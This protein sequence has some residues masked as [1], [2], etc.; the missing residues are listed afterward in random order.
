MTA[1]NRKARGASV[2]RPQDGRRSGTAIETALIEPNSL[3][4]EGVEHILARTRFQVVIRADA[5]SALDGIAAVH[6]APELAILWTEGGVHASIADIALL[7]RRYPGCRVVCIG[8][9]H[10]SE[11]NIDLLRAGADGVLL[12]SINADTFVRSL[13]LVMLG[14]RVIPAAALPMI[15]AGERAEP[16]VAPPAPPNAEM[17]SKIRR[18]LRDYNLSTRELAI[19]RCLVQ[20]ESNKIIALNLDIAEATVKVHVKAILRKIRVQNRTQAAI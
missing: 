6:R 1:E 7:R 4:R 9:S 19:L 15:H 18:G 13:E 16:L 8:Q 3:F 5:V 2:R 12:R 14:E 20:G 10:Q 17:P 11:E